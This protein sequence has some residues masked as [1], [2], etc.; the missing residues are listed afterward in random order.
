[1]RNM[2]RFTTPGNA[3][4]RAAALLALILFGWPPSLR[5]NAR[6]Q[7]SLQAVTD[8]ITYNVGEEVWLRII[9]PSQLAVHALG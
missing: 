7:A 5:L 4:W 8:Q 6:P 3:P 1:M 9:P 2:G